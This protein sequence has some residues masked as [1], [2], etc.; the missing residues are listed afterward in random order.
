ML[1][2]DQSVSL[3]GITATNNHTDCSL[4]THWTSVVGLISCILTHASNDI[5]K[6]KPIPIVQ[7]IR[8][9]FVDDLN[10]MKR[11]MQIQRVQLHLCAKIEKRHF[12]KKN[13]KLKT[14]PN[15]NCKSEIGRTVPNEHL[16]EFM[17]QK[18]EM[19]SLRLWKKRRQKNNH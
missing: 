10:E 12:T 5:Q 11:K 7:S 6:F 13:N 14:K 16:I 3:S 18:R 17:E 9:S 1:N 2:W 8:S 15:G 19:K 4:N